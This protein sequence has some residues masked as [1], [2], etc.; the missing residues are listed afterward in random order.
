ME[1]DLRQVNDGESWDKL[2]EERLKQ[3]LIDVPADYYEEEIFFNEPD[4]LN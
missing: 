3:D 4:Q 2:F 1:L